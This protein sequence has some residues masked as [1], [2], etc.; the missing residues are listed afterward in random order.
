MIGISKIRTVFVIIII[1]ILVSNSCKKDQEKPEYYGHWT[2]TETDDFFGEEITIVNT[3]SLT[4]SSYTDKLKYKF[5]GEEIE[6]YNLKG[7]LD[8]DENTFTVIFNEVGVAERDSI[9]NN[10]TGNFIQVESFE[11]E[12]REIL[13]DHGYDTISIIEYLI[14]ENELILIRDSD[15]IVYKKN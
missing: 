10:L 13:L 4:G 12:F 5:M 14:R 8:V 9:Y 3:I 2:K 11:P 6:Y 15:S 7:D 1:I